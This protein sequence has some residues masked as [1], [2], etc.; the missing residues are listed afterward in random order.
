MV[1][2]FIFS[3]ISAVLAGVC[4]FMIA[5]HKCN[6]IISN[7]QVSN[8][9]LDSKL[10]CLK[11]EYDRNLRQK[12]S[13]F[14]DEKNRFLSEKA[15]LSSGYQKRL[16]DAKISAEQEKAEV[17]ARWQ[18]RLSE[19]NETA[20]QNRDELQKAHD[21]QFANQQANFEKQMSLFSG[22]LNLQTQEMLK[23]R[24]DELH[25]SNETRMS[26]I[27]NPLLMQI[28]QLN[29]QLNDTKQDTAVKEARFQEVLSGFVAQASSMGAATDKLAHAMLSNNKIH[30]NWGELVLKQILE[31]SGL[32]EGVHFEVQQSSY[33][34]DGN[35]LRPDVY[36][37]CPGNRQIVIDSKVSLKA[38]ANYVD[39]KTSEEAQQYEEENYKALKNQI[40]NLA[41]KG[42]GKLDN[43]NFNIVLMFV[44]NEGAYILAMRH[45]PLLAQYAYDKGIVI[46]TSTNLLL[47]LQLIEGMWQKENEGERIEQ[48]L[49]SAG[50]LFEKFATFS[51]RFMAIQTNLCHA[52]DAFNDAKNYLTDGRGN[53][54][55]QITK[56]SEL[57]AKYNHSKKINKQLCDCDSIEK[58]DAQIETNIVHTTK[59]A[60]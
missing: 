38:F 31:S 54:V 28:D 3:T 55:R 13:Y 35:M 50:T 47:S 36:V 26:Q 7:L 60:V 45:D 14:E 53:I 9:S 21:A 46:L 57:G 5:K 56:L 52:S 34:E 2:I 33:D 58:I 19:V 59:V 1:T 43:N 32:T 20:S 8:A 4:A 51:D 23:A 39:A 48:I 42:Y 15:E 11:E 17:E 22:Q 37:K 6:A 49:T 29:K 24:E 25:K 30:G 16:E 18:K 12:D 41:K 27:I 10:S 40:D 44:P